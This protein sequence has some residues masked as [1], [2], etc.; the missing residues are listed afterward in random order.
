MADPVAATSFLDVVH[1]VTP[2]LSPAVAIASACIAWTAIKTPQRDRE[3]KNH[4]D[5]AVLA[6]QRAY[7]ALTCDGE[8]VRPVPADRLAWLTAARHIETYKVLKRGV[9]EPSHR[10]MC[11]DSEEYWRH[12]FYEALDMHN[13]HEASYYSEN[14][15]ENRSGLQPTSLIVVY[16]FASWP[17]GKAD[18]LDRCRPDGH[19][20]VF[21]RT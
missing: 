1:A 10:A 11:E 4:L 16:G 19:C 8:N 3:S 12:K 18:L 13:I 2:F 17:E 5:Q 14:R 9:T 7:N 6:L 15:A 21:R 20:C